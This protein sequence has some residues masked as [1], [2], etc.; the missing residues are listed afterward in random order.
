MIAD[1]EMP[2]RIGP[3][4]TT[5]SARKGKQQKQFAVTP[6][7]PIITEVTMIGLTVS[8]CPRAPNAEKVGIV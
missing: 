5:K 3:S 7:N 6:K 1:L 2:A 8:G 4:L